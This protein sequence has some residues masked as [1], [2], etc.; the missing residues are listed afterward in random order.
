MHSLL[1]ETFKTEIYRVSH[2]EDILLAREWP[3]R[4]QLVYHQII[5][6]QTFKQEQAP[7][8]ISPLP[9]PK[10]QLSWNSSIQ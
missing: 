8:S 2:K 9:D 3:E 5:L 10:Q 1:L 4:G 7:R 6:V